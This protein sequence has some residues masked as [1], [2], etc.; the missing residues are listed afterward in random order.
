MHNGLKVKVAGPKNTAKKSRTCPVFYEAVVTCPKDLYA[1]P[2]KSDCLPRVVKVSMV[3]SKYRA[4]LNMMQ[5]MNVSIS[6]YK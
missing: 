2:E 1:C 3:S 4:L 6:R 5:C